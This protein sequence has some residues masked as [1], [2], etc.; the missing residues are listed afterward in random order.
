MDNLE[1]VTCE[2]LDEI[3]A[4][5]SLAGYNDLKTA[6]MLVYTSGNEI[7]KSCGDEGV[8]GQVAKVNGYG[9]WR[10]AERNIRTAVE[11]VF[12]NSNSD[13][14][15]KYFNGVYDPS[16]GKATNLNF[17]YRSVSIVKRRIE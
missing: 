7:Y 9:D 3:G 13:I 11:Q 14:V 8:Y 16:K 5:N 15:V 1:K 2:F 6:I 17:I 10:R 12:M 4:P